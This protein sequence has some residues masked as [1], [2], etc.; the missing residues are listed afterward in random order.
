M[1]CVESPRQSRGF[2][3]LEVLVALVVLALTLTALIKMAGTSARDFGE[4]RERSLAQWVA[5]NVIAETRL[6]PLPDPGRRTGQQRLAGRD[7][8]WTLDVQ[9]TPEPTIRRLEVHVLRGQADDDVLVQ[10]NGPDFETVRK[11]VL[12]DL[13]RVPGILASD[14]LFTDGGYEPPLKDS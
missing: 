3:L 9:A 5:A 8:R 12:E 14:T 2:T 10:L 7:W 13:T 6:K 4:L 11:A 1:R